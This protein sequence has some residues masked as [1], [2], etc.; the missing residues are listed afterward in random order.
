MPGLGVDLDLADMAAIGEGRLRR[1]EMT[2]L[3][4][5]GLDPR[6]LLPRRRPRPRLRAQTADGGSGPAGRAGVPQHLLPAEP[7]DTAAL[8]EARPGDPPSGRE[9]SG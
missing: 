7:A 1:G 8:L 9:L 3:G 4:K 5:A 6:R 2:A